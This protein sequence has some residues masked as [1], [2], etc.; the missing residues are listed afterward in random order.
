MIKIC[1]M[2]SGVKERLLEYLYAKRISQVEFTRML[3]V[4]STYIGAMRR[5]ISDEKIQKIRKLF[6]DLNTDWLLYG[7][8]TMLQGEEKN[9]DI[10]R[11]LETLG[12][13][14]VPLLPA[15]AYA[16]N[17]QAFSEGVMSDDCEMMISQ[18]QGAE[19][20]I[21]VSGRSM[22]P[23]IPDGS[24]LFIR[25]INDRAFIPWGH[26]LVVDTDNGVVV[27]CLYPVGKGSE[28]VEA[29][30]YNPAYPPFR[31]ST[32]TVYGLYRVLAIL[33]YCSTM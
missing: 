18:V 2:A 15:A 5:S 26:P 22:E 20:V 4:S 27:K 8:G 30:S 29:H 1:D 25:R 6:P 31:I 17:I 10:R 33:S 11:E 14:M 16:G 32:D 24:Y 13:S 19:M 7:E 9:D 3:G 21:R 23:N 12:A 28:E